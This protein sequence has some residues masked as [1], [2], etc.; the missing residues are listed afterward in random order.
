MAAGVVGLYSFD[1]YGLDNEAVQARVGAGRGAPG[2]IA[3]TASRGG[4]GG[5]A[6]GVDG[7]HERGCWL[8]FA[9]GAHRMLDTCSRGGSLVQ[10]H[11]SLSD[12]GSGLWTQVSCC[13]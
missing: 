11:L 3:W 13:G 5:G 9:V 1:P 2:Q 4:A 7:L 12:W 6:G 10:H 8:D